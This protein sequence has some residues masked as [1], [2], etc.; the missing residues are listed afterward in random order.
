MSL[1]KNSMVFALCSSGIFFIFIPRSCLRHYLNNEE[2]VL[3]MVQ[4]AS[5]DQINNN[6]KTNDAF[7]YELKD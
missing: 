2:T 6:S 7:V 1:K 5:N 3:E 4:S